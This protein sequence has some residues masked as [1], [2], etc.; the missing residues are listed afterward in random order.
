MNVA[1][2]AAFDVLSL[3]SGGGGLDLGLRLAVPW[4]RTVGYVE[5]EAYAAAVLVA[6][7]EAA[8]LGAAPL[9]DDVAA[10][11]G[12]PWRGLV[13]CVAGG[14]PCQDI[15]NAGNR[16]GI[17]GE[18]SGLWAH[19]ARIICEVRPRYVFVENVAA[20]VVRGLDVVLADLAALGFDAEW[21]VL[22]ADEVGAPHQR[23]RLFILAHAHG[24][25]V[26]QLAERDLQGQA[27][28]LHAVPRAAGAGMADAESRG[29]GKLR[30]SPR[31]G[32]QLECS[33]AEAV[34]DAA[35][36][37]ERES[38][39]AS[40]ADARK[41]AWLDAGGRGGELAD[42]VRDGL[43]GQHA[44]RAAGRAALGTDPALAHAHLGRCEGERRGGLLDGKRTASGDDADRCGGAPAEVADADVGA[45]DGIPLG[46]RARILASDSGARS[47]WRAPF[48][49]GPDDRAGWEAYLRE[50]P[51]IEPAIRRGTDG[52]AYRMERLRLLGNG[53]VPQQAARA[54]TELWERL[55]E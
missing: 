53:V 42:A 6:R 34:A 9:W 24:D 14:F 43:E 39:H 32:G 49:P 17:E 7:M 27:L 3:F 40:G 2:P 4:A 28:G 35:G 12:R 47:L 21:I 29:L 1:L 18:R 19:F 5:R 26:R 36:E 37:R 13:D 15:S 55:H 8:D 30:E 11:D 23:D 20:L 41:R 45:G 54:F 10:F 25:A 16:V 52:L 46:E 51:G 38:H 31:C 44:G 50:W 48:P 22:G 33:R